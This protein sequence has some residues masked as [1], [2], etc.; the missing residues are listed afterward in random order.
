MF[1]EIYDSISEV[2]IY[3]ISQ[4]HPLSCPNEQGY[5]RDHYHELLT[6]ICYIPVHT[7]LR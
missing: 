4:F 2:W 7:L 1:P 3:S 5:I 6:E